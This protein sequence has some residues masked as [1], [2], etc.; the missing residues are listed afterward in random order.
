MMI[1]TTTDKKI[2]YIETVG[3]NVTFLILKQHGK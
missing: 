3:M 1:M 2:G